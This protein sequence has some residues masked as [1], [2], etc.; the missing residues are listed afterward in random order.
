MGA[1]IDDLTITERLLR[2]GHDVQEGAAFPGHR[3]IVRRADG[4][5]VGEMRAHEAVRLLH[6]LE[7]AKAV[8]P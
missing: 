5:C 4:V 8:Q 1:E 2:V 7:A 3:R 6:K